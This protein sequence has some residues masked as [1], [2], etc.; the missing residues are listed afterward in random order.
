M[1]GIS[2]LLTAMMIFMVG[3]IPMNIGTNEVVL[4]AGQVTGAPD[5]EY[6]INM[7]TNDGTQPGIVTLD[8]SA[9]DFVFSDIDRSIN[10]FVPD[11][12]L[13]SENGAVIRNCA[14]AVYFDGLEEDGVTIE[15]ITFNC[16]GSG[17]ISVYPHQNVVI[18]G[19]TFH[20]ADYVLRVENASNWEIVD[21]TG[22]AL[23]YFPGILIVNA[24]DM[25]IRENMITAYEGI[26]LYDANN[27][28]VT[29]NELYAAIHGITIVNSSSD[30]RVSNNKI[31][32]IQDAGV[33]L[34]G[35]SEHNKILAN[36][37]QCAGSFSCQAVL[38]ESSSSTNKVAGNK[39][40]SDQSPL[41]FNATLAPGVWSTFNLGVTSRDVAYVVDVTPLND[42]V[43][44]AY[45]PFMIKPEYDG[46]QWN[47]VLRVM[48]PSEFPEQ[49]VRITVFVLSGLTTILDMTD[50]LPPGEWRGYAF[51][52]PMVDIP[53]AYLV[54]LDPLGP[55]AQGAT[56]ERYLLHPEFFMDEWWDVLRVQTVNWLPANPLPVRTRVYSAEDLV[57]AAD[58]NVTLTKN[59]LWSGWI[60]GPS[61]LERGYVI[62]AIPLSG[63][64]QSDLDG[65]F[66]Q[67][68]FDAQNQQW[69]DVLRVR[70]GNPY[71]DWNS[72]E[73]N[74]K[75]YAC[76]NTVC[77]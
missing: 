37:V 40:V 38:D 46:S 48:V 9:G 15:G 17:V 43:A 41:T 34:R 42:S 1:K 51:G 61:S 59:D 58:F 4:N 16:D 25:N 71:A 74:F 39:S 18:R 45:T 57:L 33:L 73:Y 22:N 70:M 5:I 11:L 67:P 28:S 69:N 8:S 29:R 12:I 21:N 31:L 63:D 36:R 75:V 76:D 6:A 77:P 30:N 49:D 2:I 24:T 53:A 10:I 60:I 68:E 27:N 52:H 62:R 65:Y 35:N 44:G 32:N 47:D 3:A 26:S 56:F 72:V 54:D 13:R 64:T 7:A 19:N 66:I 23:K 55:S 14:D 50:S 20:I